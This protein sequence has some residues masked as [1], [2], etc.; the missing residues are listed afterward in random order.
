M[1][2]IWLLSHAPSNPYRARVRPKVIESIGQLVAEGGR[3]LVITR[4]R[5]PDVEPDGSP[6]PLSDK[7][8]AQ[9]QELGLQ[10]I[11]HDSFGDADNDS[12]KKL[13]IEYVRP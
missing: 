3:L 8:L 12:I 7:E 4:V 11:R 6:W 13:R 10:E 2:S 5:D 9:F 1:P